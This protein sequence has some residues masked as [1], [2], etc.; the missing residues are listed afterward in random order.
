MKM[1]V[2]D[3]IL[4]ALYAFLGGALLVLGGLN[5]MGV[6]LN[7][8]DYVV[9]AVT[10]HLADSLWAKV[11]FYAA[12]LILIV[13][14]LHLVI[15]SFRR[16]KRKDKGCVSIQNTG[17]GAV[18]ISVQAMDAL[19]RRAIGEV[20]G[21][22]D[23]KTKVINHEDSITVE[24][25]MA[26]SADSHIPNVT[27]VMQRNIRRYIEEFSG[28]AVREVLVLVNEIRDTVPAIPAPKAEPTPASEKPVVVEPVAVEPVAEEPASEPVAEPAAECVEEPAAEEPAAECVEKPA[29]EEPAAECVEEPAAEEPAAEYAEEPAAEEPAAECV[30]E[31]AAEEP[32]AEYAEEPAEDEADE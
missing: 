8:V 23:M 13:W 5:V 6:R 29:A 32:A 7:F 15:L 20:E 17:D 4:L 19:V 26:L 27:M 14:S 28:I 30:E 9:D 21:V 3:R 12:A 10:Y 1:R 18:R 24:I 31:P 22:L 16:E 11:V 2:I 25:K